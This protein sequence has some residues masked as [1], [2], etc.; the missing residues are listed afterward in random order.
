MSGLDARPI[1]CPIAWSADTQVA[2]LVLKICDFRSGTEMARVP[3][4]EPCEVTR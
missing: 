4:S 1:D 2:P 3:V